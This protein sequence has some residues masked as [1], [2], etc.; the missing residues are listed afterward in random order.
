MDMHQNEDGRR[1]PNFYCDGMCDH[2]DYMYVI[3][4]SPDP[5]NWTLRYI[6]ERKI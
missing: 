5:N 1:D 4:D 2:N 3:W 6:K